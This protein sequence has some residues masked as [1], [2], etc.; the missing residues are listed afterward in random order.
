MRN[1]Q[2]MSKQF[3]ELKENISKGKFSD[4]QSIKEIGSVI[5]NLNKSVESLWQTM[6]KALKLNEK[7]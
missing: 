6:K 4:N 7:L 3:A 5:G 2:T 1:V